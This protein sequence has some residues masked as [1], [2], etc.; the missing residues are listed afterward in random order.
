MFQRADKNELRTWLIGDGFI[1]ICLA[2][3]SVVLIG[4]IFTKGFTPGKLVWGIVF[5]L[6]T[7]LLA[8]FFVKIVKALKSY[9]ER[10]TKKEEL[11]KI[12]K[13]KQ[14]EESLAA[15]EREKAEM[16]A[17]REQELQ[18]RAEMQAEL[19]ALKAEKE[20]NGEKFG[21]DEE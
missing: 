21:S 11:E 12:E 4:S 1:T 6:L 16:D 9:D 18:K 19:E 17:L 13:Q 7:I 10:M 15:L 14:E 3:T 2:L 20:A 8:L 5:S